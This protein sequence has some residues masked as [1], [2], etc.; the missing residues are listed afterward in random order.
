MLASFQD[1]ERTWIQLLALE[2]LCENNRNWVTPES[3]LGVVLLA[4]LGRD[5]PPPL[6]LRSVIVMCEG[7][8][9]QAGKGT[10]M[11]EGA[12]ATTRVTAGPA[13]REIHAITGLVV[14]WTSLDCISH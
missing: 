2:T 14:S 13:Q 5:P 10:G 3:G 12:P 1:S 11:G 8:E 4:I 9:G 6:N 7:G